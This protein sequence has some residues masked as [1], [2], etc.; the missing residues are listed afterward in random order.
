MS[1]ADILHVRQ[2]ENYLVTDFT[3]SERLRDDPAVMDILAQVSREIGFDRV[4]VWE[5]V[6]GDRQLLSAIPF[7]EWENPHFA[8]STPGRI[9]AQYCALLHECYPL[10]TDAE[11]HGGQIAEIIK[12]LQ[13]KGHAAQIRWRWLLPDLAPPFQTTPPSRDW[14]P[15]SWRSWPNT[16]SRG[17]TK[18]SG[19]SP[20]T[21]SPRSGRTTGRGL[22][23]DTLPV[24]KWGFL[25]DEGVST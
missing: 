3:R 4:R 5:R 16:T 24:L 10:P 1:A 17:W 23:I 2:G 13:K 8:S 18:H 9:A 15:R 20:D 14:P 11:T 12:Y 21:G 22:C 19:R 25:F 7:A 6:D